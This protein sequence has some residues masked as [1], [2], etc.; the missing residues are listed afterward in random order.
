MIVNWW[1]GYSVMDITQYKLEVNAKFTSN[2]FC[3]AM[4]MRQWICYQANELDIW[5]WSN[6]KFQYRLIK[7]DKGIHVSQVTQKSLG[8]IRS[9][10]PIAQIYR[11]L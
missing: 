10:L 9:K 8:F 3:E 2:T 11:E 1:M 4:L 6:K 5:V 7:K